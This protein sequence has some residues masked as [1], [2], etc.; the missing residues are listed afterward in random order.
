M[1]KKYIVLQSQK[2]KYRLYSEDIKTVFI[3]PT[4]KIPNVPRFHALAKPYE[5]DTEGED[6]SAQQPSHSLSLP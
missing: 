1:G 3:K 5:S 4:R 2:K 6:L